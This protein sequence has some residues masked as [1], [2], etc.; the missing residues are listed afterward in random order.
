MQWVVS[1]CGK[2]LVPL[3]LGTI[4]VSMDVTYLGTFI[5]ELNEL[6]CSDENNAKILDGRTTM[7]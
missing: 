5:E 7:L 1:D 3:P 4:H 6:Y 2:F